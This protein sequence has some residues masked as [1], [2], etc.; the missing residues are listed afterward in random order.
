MILI[1]VG[2]V[3]V[4]TLTIFYYHFCLKERKTLPEGHEAYGPADDGQG[5][6][7]CILAI[8]ENGKELIPGKLSH[9]KVA[10]Y[11]YHGREE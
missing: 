11:T 8:K 10:T 9:H 3:I 7:K 6:Y 4:I 5:P 2:V 1:I